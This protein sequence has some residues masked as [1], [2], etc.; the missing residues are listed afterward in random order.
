VSVNQKFLFFLFHLH[1]KSPLLLHF[2]IISHSISQLTHDSVLNQSIILRSQSPNQFIPCFY[3]LLPQFPSPLPLLLSPGH[4]IF[5]C[6]FLKCYRDGSIRIF[7]V[8]LS[9]VPC[10]YESIIT[11]PLT[12]FLRSSC[13]CFFLG[14]IFGWCQVQYVIISK[15]VEKLM[16]EVFAFLQYDLSMGTI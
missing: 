3:C 12:Y 6:F 11:H 4:C 7:L 1:G 16:V 10:C 5:Q 2:S 9:L 8:I 13:F 14:A 15:I